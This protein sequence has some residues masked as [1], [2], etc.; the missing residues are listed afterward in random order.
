MVL[1]SIFRRI[2]RSPAPSAAV[3]PRQHA[4]SWYNVTKGIL[5]S[6]FFLHAFAEYGYSYSSASGPSMLP[7]LSVIGDWIRVNRTYRRGRNIR[8]GD[9]VAFH[10]PVFS[11]ARGVKRVIGMPGDYVLLDKPGTSNPDPPMIQVCSPELLVPRPPQ[12]DLSCRF[13]RAT[14]G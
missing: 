4:G 3:K 8:V 1:R 6:V 5:F 13:Q 12:T 10:H 7:T 2:A 11:N 9:L 14:V